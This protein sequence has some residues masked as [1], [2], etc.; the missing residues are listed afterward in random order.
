MVEGLFGFQ[1]LGIPSA[2]SAK[3]GEPAGGISDCP[4]KAP[5]GAGETP[6]EGHDV[7]SA[8][9]EAIGRGAFP[10]SPKVISSF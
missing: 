8:Q 5:K 4:L 6:T 10:A 3:V 1:L 7:L 9:A 2:V